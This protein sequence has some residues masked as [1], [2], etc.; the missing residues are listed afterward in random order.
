MTGKQGA[1][2]ITPELHVFGC[3]RAARVIVRWLYQAGYIQVGQIANRRLDSAR[4][5]VEFIGAGRA[6]ESLDATIAGGWLLLGLPDG[7]L[8]GQARR[9][10]DALSERPA[11]VFHLSGSAPSSILRPI[12]NCIA[13]V[14]PVR[15][16]A[17][18]ATALPAMPGT[19]CCAE[20]QPRALAALEPAFTAAGG[21]WLLISSDHKRLYHAATVTASNALVALTAMARELGVSAGLEAGQAAELIGDLQASTLDNLRGRP[22]AAALTGPIERGDVAGV[23]ALVEAIDAECPDLSPAF[24][25]LAARTLELAIEKR[26]RRE[27]DSVLRELLTTSRAD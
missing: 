1:P 12:S 11:L 7:E 3:G 22:A 26:G 10:A 20:G 19:W 24:R 13:S 23:G 8:D 27:G 5:A 25:A 6:V 16:F 2:E 18:P 9:L 21:R 4:A 14:H 17:D 15:S